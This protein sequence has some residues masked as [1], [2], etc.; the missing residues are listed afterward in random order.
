MKT[1]ILVLAILLILPLGA[2]ALPSPSP[3]SGTPIVAQPAATF[4][5]YATAASVVEVGG[6]IT[7]VNADA[8]RHNVVS[9]EPGAEDR[10]W[11]AGYGI[12][13]CPLFWSPLINVGQTTPVLGLDR[14][15][16]G[17]TYT[18]Y[19]TLHTGMQGTLVALP[20]A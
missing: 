9:R 14:I 4:S 7:F 12:G 18:F 5:T 6:E 1:A 15:E 13:R 19:C 20:E 11:C 3:V 8:F 16:A 2:T 17:N 10:P